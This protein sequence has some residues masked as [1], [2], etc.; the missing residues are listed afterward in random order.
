M[1]LIDRSFVRSPRPYILQSLLATVSVAILLYFVQIITQAAI[2]TAL[3]ASAFIAFALPESKIAHPRRL[4][5]GHVVGIISGIACYYML[6]VAPIALGLRWPYLL[7]VAAA[8]SVGLSMFL[9]TILNAEHPP[10]ASTALG[11]VVNPWSYQTI[12]VIL[13]FAGSLAVIKWLLR[14]HIK[15]LF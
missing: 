10:A 7:L 3:G 4:V 15:S 9:M 11:M 6:I 14:N 8:I 2:V 13:M 12:L 5:G 1:D